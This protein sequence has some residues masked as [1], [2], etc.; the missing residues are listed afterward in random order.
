MGG[1][2]SKQFTTTTLPYPVRDVTKGLSVSTSQGCKD[3]RLKL[4]PNISSSSITLMRDDVP[5]VTGAALEEIRKAAFSVDTKIIIQPTI[6]FTVNFNGEDF[7]IDSMSLYKPS[8]IRI[9]NVQH[10]AV[11]SLGSQLSKLI[12]LIPIIADS[13]PGESGE[14]LSRI[15]SRVSSITTPDTTGKFPNIEVP[16]GSDWNLTKVIPLDPNTGEVRG[17]F[18]SWAGTGPLT[19]TTNLQGNVFVRSWVPSGETGPQYIMMKDP[20]KISAGDLATIQTLPITKPEYAIHNIVEDT[21]VYRPGP[22][23]TCSTEDGVLG[24]ECD[25]FAAME[26]KTTINAQLLF[27]IFSAFATFILSVIVVYYAIKYA[28]KQGVGDSIYNFGQWLGKKIGGTTKTPV[29][30]SVVPP[31]PS[32]TFANPLLAAY[33]APGRFKSSRKKTPTA[34]VPRLEAAE[35]I[36]QIAPVATP[37]AEAVEQ[38]TPGLSI[39]TPPEPTVKRRIIAPSP[40]IEEE[41][42][43][44]EAAAQTVEQI[45]PAAGTGLIPTVPPHLRKSTMSNLFGVD[46][47]RTTARNKNVV[48]PDLPQV[49]REIVAPSVQP[50]IPFEQRV[51]YAKELAE[52]R[53]QRLGLQTRRN[54]GP[55]WTDRT[56]A[57]S[58]E[59][60]EQ[61]AALRRETAREKRR[62]ELAQSE[63]NKTAEQIRQAKSSI[64]NARKLTLSS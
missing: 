39:R 44:T 58:N 1:G 56:T 35:T 19:Q 60:D 59:T 32:G 8:P 18:F 28:A 25:P 42:A 4:Y 34:E 17:G 31:T 12:I 30:T 3:C 45:N 41:A 13:S 54:A 61:I 62:T 6:P 36:E 55:S 10:D 24:K 7:T 2:G 64:K 47:R 51:K 14:F 50:K 15:A 20:A 22:P 46:A 57:A 27:T 11:L 23:S 43:A 37:A 63:A 49:A 5:T 48:P 33:G 53:K 38:I 29:F 26:P 21:V 52:Q 16:T 40:P 9:E